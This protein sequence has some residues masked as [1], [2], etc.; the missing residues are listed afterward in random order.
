[1]TLSVWNNIMPKLIEFMEDIKAKR[2]QRERVAAVNKRRQM[3]ATILNNYL[4]TRSLTEVIPCIADVC[5]MKEIKSIIEDTPIDVE[6]N[7]KSFANIVPEL[8]RLI[9]EWR[10]SKSR[11]LITMMEAEAPALI[12]TE[13]TDL[14]AHFDLSP[15]E[16]ATTWFFCR[17]CDEPI[18]YPRILAHDHAIA[19]TPT[20]RKDGPRDHILGLSC[21]AWNF[22]GDRLKFHVDAHRAARP[23]VESCG[24]DPDTTTARQMDEFDPMVECLICRNFGAGRIAMRW[25]RAVCSFIGSCRTVEVTTSWC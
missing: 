4:L 20:L 16:L 25:R 23:I 21:Q 18:G 17:N 7:A 22:R 13:E 6:V 14:A 9:D 2:L 1:M 12:K 10:I 11:E 5:E 3:M 8:P 15:L 19:M 24:L